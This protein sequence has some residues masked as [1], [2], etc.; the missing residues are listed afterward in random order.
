MR[1]TAHTCSHAC[2]RP[3]SPPCYDTTRD[4]RRSRGKGGIGGVGGGGG[5]AGNNS[6]YT[7]EWLEEDWLA[8]WLGDE[9]VVEAVLG[10]PDPSGTGRANGDGSKGDGTDQ[11]SFR[12]VRFAA[13]LLFGILF[14]F[15]PVPCSELRGGVGVVR[16]E[17][18]LL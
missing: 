6:G 17:Q 14:Y 7:Y 12:T 1:L 8:S 4:R 11:V 10:D 16:T 3:F 2:L 13:C 9:Q 18:Q 15:L 5:G